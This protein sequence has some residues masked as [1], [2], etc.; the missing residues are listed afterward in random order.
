MLY[1][2]TMRRRDENSV[3]DDELKFLIELAS[4]P[5]KFYF[6]LKKNRN[7]RKQNTETEQGDECDFWNGNEF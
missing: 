7:S 5:I 4:G 6:I 3:Y 1:T 2:L